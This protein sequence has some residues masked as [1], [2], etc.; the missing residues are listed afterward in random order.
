V[1]VPETVQF[2][3]QPNA[4]FIITP[5]MMFIDKETMQKPLKDIETLDVALAK[6]PTKALYKLQVSIAQE[7]QSRARVDTTN[8]QIAQ[9]ETISLK[10]ALNLEAQQK[11]KAKKKVEEMEQQIHM[12]F[13][14]IP[15]STSDEAGSSGEKLRRIEQTIQEYK[16]KI[17]ELEEHVT[18]TT[19]PEV[20]A[21]SSYIVVY[22]P[23]LPF[24]FYSA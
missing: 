7:I 12:L 6:I 21:C 18:P 23:F 5:E 10:E 11:E 16:E 24:Y 1:P 14:T 20:R 15:E 2:A 3:A 22:L 13:Q 8:L 4:N 9:T 19:P 17:K